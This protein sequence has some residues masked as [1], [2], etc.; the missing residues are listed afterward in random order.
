VTARPAQTFS[1]FW[2]ARVA[3]A[4]DALFLR[5]DERNWTYR[6][7][8][9]WVDVLAARLAELGVGAR[10]HV[11]MLLPSGVELLRLQWALRKLGAVWVPAIPGSTH[12]EAAHVIRHSLAEVLV[13][14]QAHW[15][16]L[17][18]GGG[19]GS[20]V[21]PYLTDGDEPE[22]PHLYG[23]SAP[24]VAE[25]PV[26]PGEHP[27]DPIAI[28]YTS[29][30]TSRPKGVLVKGRGFAAIG[31]SV[32]DRLGVTVEDRWYGLLPL[33]HA[34]AFLVTAPAIAR[35]GS[36][37]LRPKFSRTA[38]WSD[39]RRH[40]TT[41][42]FLMPAM[43]SMLLGE[44]PR[45]DDADN[46][47]RL[48]S[49]HARNEPFARRFGVTLCT[50]WTSTETLGAGALSPPGFADSRPGVIGPV[51]PDDAE[52]KA[53]DEN[54]RDLPPGED[55]ELCV[56]HP[57]VTPGYFRDPANTAAALRNGW[58][59]TGDLGAVDDRGVVT[60]R[61]RIKNMIKRLGENVAGE[62]VELAFLEHEDVEEC[63]VCGVP[64]PVRT[65]EV[66]ATVVVRPG[67]AVT[68]PELAGWCRQ[69]L[70]AWKVPRYIRLI[71]EPFPRLANGKVD[72][73]RVGAT[74]DVTT[75]WDRG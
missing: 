34:G 67:A 51:I 4:P 47:L 64:D 8:D 48:A 11:A 15:R 33:F 58:M 19:L 32:A 9:R 1:A 5:A 42:T 39:V 70:S 43:M 66:F 2:D 12:A 56:R 23:P 35:G 28:M 7:F 60:Y 20:A 55:G 75:A 13:T 31:H 18:D 38:F 69:R 71:T 61:G 21:R 53:V 50:S 54:G 30:S 44:P 40:G 27:D 63:V 25:P 6:E 68:E 16:V 72:R 59:H 22:A 62:E 24:A 74:V 46:P 45:P 41:V 49:T 36:I 52:V 10:M 17:Q 57:S 65:E 37:V 14:D 73:R 3:A 29:G 26:P